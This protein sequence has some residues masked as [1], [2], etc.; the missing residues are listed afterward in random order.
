MP[1]NLGNRC[2]CY[3]PMA[4]FMAWVR[5]ARW[6]LQAGKYL[7]KSV[8]F[9]EIRHK[10]QENA[11]LPP[12]KRSYE[13][14]VIPFHHRSGGKD[15]INFDRARA[16]RATTRWRSTGVRG[17]AAQFLFHAFQF[18]AESL[19]PHTGTFAPRFAFR[20]RLCGISGDF[21]AVNILVTFSLALEFCA[22]FIFR[23]MQYLN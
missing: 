9:G 5:C 6:G 18:L 4:I 2:T 3:R 1:E 13:I 7:L 10:S 11:G 23:H 14:C 12:F 21:A 22:Q 19:V 16:G 15:R 8:K 17:V 20:I